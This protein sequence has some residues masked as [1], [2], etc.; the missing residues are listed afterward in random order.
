VATSATRM[1]DYSN[2]ETSRFGD[3]RAVWAIARANLRVILSL[4][5]FFWVIISC[6]CCTF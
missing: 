1:I 3:I 5:G 6:R 4:A 2:V